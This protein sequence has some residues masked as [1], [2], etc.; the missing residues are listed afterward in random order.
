MFVTSQMSLDGALSTDLGQQS[1][2]NYSSC[3]EKLS[4]LLMVAGRSTPRYQ[5][6]AQLYSRSRLLQSHLSEYFIIIVQ[7]CHYLLGLTK[8]SL[9]G[10]L[11]S[12]STDDARMKGFEYDLARWAAAVK[13]EVSFLMSEKLDEQSAG[14]KMLIKLSSSQSHSRKLV[15]RARVLDACSTY[16]HET[17]WKDIRKTGKATLVQQM[18]EYGSWRSAEDSS[19]LLV[20]GKLGAVCMPEVICFERTLWF[21]VPTHRQLTAV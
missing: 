11:A 12:L 4:T 15:D 10:Q 3:L 19:T 9:L 17:T 21:D 2:V 20:L 18:P 6:M 1:L 13:E 14:I 16:E 5:K 8:R 7:L